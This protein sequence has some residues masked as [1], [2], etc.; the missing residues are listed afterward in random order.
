MDGV[1]QRLGVIVH[2]RIERDRRGHRVAAQQLH[3]IVT[4]EGILHGDAEGVGL[5][6]GRLLVEHDE[7]V[8]R[9]GER[10][11]LVG[12]GI[13]QGGIAR[14]VVHGHVNDA[15]LK[16]LQSSFGVGVLLQ[17]DGL[18][19]ELVRVGIVGIGQEGNALLV[20]HIRAR[21]DG[22]YM[23][24]HLESA[25][26]D[27]GDVQELDKLAVAD[28]EGHGHAV[29][30][31]GSALEA[32]KAPAVAVVV[33]GVADGIDQV[34]PFHGG[35]VGEVV[36]VVAV[37]GE[38]PDRGVVVRGPRADDVGDRV[39]VLIHLDHML[40]DQVADQLVGVVGGDEGVEGV[41]R[42]GVQR[43][44]VVHGLGSREVLAAAGFG[45]LVLV[46]S[47]AVRA[48]RQRENHH[49]SQEQGKK[50]SHG[51]SSRSGIMMQA[52]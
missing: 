27:D 5:A 45:D 15:V 32:G 37:Q 10:V 12:A 11:D 41:V 40:I 18:K 23:G 6:E 35:S 29:I 3:Q 47:A 14:R 50:T 48:G 4:V 9:R 2:G 26:L 44:H 7:V 28:A 25:G 49:D 20:I 51:V 34:L 39:E 13:A 33:D 42:V 19:G 8:V 1:G 22:R 43:E 36:G 30:R 21:A 17:I 52:A 24:L 31:V 16:G 46:R 38:G